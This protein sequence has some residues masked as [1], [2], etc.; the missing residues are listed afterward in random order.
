MSVGDET[1]Y[2]VCQ[3]CN[4]ACDVT[5][6]ECSVCH[7]TS[8]VVD[9]SKCPFC[10]H[11]QELIREGRAMSD[12]KTHDWVD[13]G[14]QMTKKEMSLEK[15]LSDFLSEWNGESHLIMLQ[16]NVTTDPD[17]LL[18]FI[19]SQLRGAVEGERVLQH[20]KSFNTGYKA[21]I[22]RLPASYKKGIED[23]LKTLQSECDRT[24]NEGGRVLLEWYRGKNEV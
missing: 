1:S 11:D 2:W 3:K 16:A 24:E 13:K 20:T 10:E 18:N 8:E 7:R 12:L 4:K 6:N 23:T 9:M 5:G 15:K 21:G 17:K 19:S 22:D 14:F